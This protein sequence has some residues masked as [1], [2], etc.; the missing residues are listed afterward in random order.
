MKITSLKN[1]FI[2][3]SILVAIGHTGVA[4]AHQGGD[5]LDAAGNNESA[6][7]LATV[8]CFDDG[9]GPAEHLIMQ[10]RDVSPSVP[11]LLTSLHIYKGRQITTIT[12]NVSGD[13]NYTQA[14]RLNGG[15]GVYYV[16]ISHTQAGQR[17]YELIWHCETSGGAH[18][19]TDAELLQHQ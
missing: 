8:T 7:N 15:N 12:D 10:L 14:V 11:G 1:A 3:A 17:F 19:G 4:L 9:N 13:A 2:S 16:S 18:T 5:V 6:T